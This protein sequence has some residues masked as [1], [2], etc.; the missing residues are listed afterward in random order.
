V[1]SL[2]LACSVGE[3]L[4]KVAVDLGVAAAG[5]LTC[6]VLPEVVPGMG[7]TSALS[8]NVG[9]A[10]DAGSRTGRSSPVTNV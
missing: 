8:P 3:A 7:V 6:A 2:V 10:G 1:F 9:R 4:I 5:V